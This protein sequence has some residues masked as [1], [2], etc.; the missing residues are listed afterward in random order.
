MRITRSKE[1]LSP[2][3]LGDNESDLTDS[4][5]THMFHA[6]QHRWGSSRAA[7]GQALRSRGNQFI[8]CQ[9]L[10]DEEQKMYHSCMRPRTC[11]GSRGH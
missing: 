10:C 2:T 4:I 7:E 6:T 1:P 11:L 5:P 3:N 9:C 8:G